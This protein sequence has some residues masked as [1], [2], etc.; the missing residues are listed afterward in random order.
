MSYISTAGSVLPASEYLPPLDTSRS[1][2]PSPPI[3]PELEASFT[4]STLNYLET[5]TAKQLRLPS[6]PPANISHSPFLVP[7]GSV[8]NKIR[9]K[10]PALL[11][12]PSHLTDVPEGT[13]PT[14]SIISAS[15]WPEPPRQIP[16]PIASVSPFHDGQQTFSSIHPYSSAAV[17]PAIV[18]HEENHDRRPPSPAGTSVTEFLDAYAYLPY[19]TDPPFSNIGPSVMN[20]PVKPV[21]PAKIQES[22]LRGLDQEGS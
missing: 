19:E 3:S 10:Q 7:S 9:A 1:A 12:P 13:T 14:P 22:W 15:A 4:E 17:I 18:T 6:P 8:A 16:S 11:T 20:V 5:N 21:K 2:N